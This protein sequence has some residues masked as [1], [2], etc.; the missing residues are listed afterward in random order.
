MKSKF[1]RNNRK[2]KWKN[3][4]KTWYSTIDTLDTS[5]RRKREAPRKYYFTFIFLLCYSVWYII[6]W[7]YN[8]LRNTSQWNQNKNVIWDLELE[9]S[10]GGM[11]MA[12]VNVL[13]YHIPKWLLSIC[14]SVVC[15]HA[16]INFILFQKYREFVSFSRNNKHQHQ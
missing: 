3:V 6:S 15:P 5:R 13:F 8:E 14:M 11:V 4:R 12:K 16:S 9:R 2:P 1:E 10:I 7:L